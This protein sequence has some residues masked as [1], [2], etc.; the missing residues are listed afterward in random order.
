MYSLSQSKSIIGK[1]LSENYFIVQGAIK[2][3]FQRAV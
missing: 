2:R 1:W 3:E